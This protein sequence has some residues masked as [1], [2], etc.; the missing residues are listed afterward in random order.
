MKFNIYN[1]G[2]DYPQYCIVRKV[3]SEIVIAE[4]DETLNPNSELIYEIV[5]LDADYIA[6]TYYTASYPNDLKVY[7]IENDELEEIKNNGSITIPI[8]QESSDGIKRLRNIKVEYS[9]SHF[10]VTNLSSDTSMIIC[11]VTYG[12]YDTEST[13]YH[14]SDLSKYEVNDTKVYNLTYIDTTMYYKLS[15][16]NDYY[17]SLVTLTDFVNSESFKIDEARQFYIDIHKRLGITLSDEGLEVLNN[18][19]DDEFKTWIIN[20]DVT[21]TED[22]TTTNSTDSKLDTHSFA[23]FYAHECTDYDYVNKLVNATSYYMPM[24]YASRYG[25]GGKFYLKE[26]SDGLKKININ[27]DYKV[28]GVEYSLSKTYYFKNNTL[29]DA[30]MI[31]CAHT[32][33]NEIYAY[34]DTIIPGSLFLY[35]TLFKAYD[36]NVKEIYDNYVFTTEMT[37]GLTVTHFNIDTEEIGS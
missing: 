17:V 27:I 31:A 36:E 2:N 34:N 10:M 16:Y 11:K 29:Y 28:S 26:L 13:L 20:N 4:E 22:I 23:R 12:N 37:A 32:T 9:D 5:T 35:C 18:L 33:K 30:D 21:I 25:S 1:T 15:D 24:Y 8:V 19:S 3:K 7:Y 6:V 14:L